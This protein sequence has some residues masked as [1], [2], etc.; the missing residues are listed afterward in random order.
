M[1]AWALASAGT[2]WLAGTQDRALSESWADPE[3]GWGQLVSDIAAV[4]GPALVAVSALLLLPR[5]HMRVSGRAVALAVLQVAVA[6]GG[7]VLLLKVL[8][9][10][11]RPRMV[12]EGEQWGVD[13]DCS[14]G[15][16]QRCRFTAWY[17]PQGPRAGRLSFPSEHAFWGWLPGVA[18]LHWRGVSGAVA[19]RALVWVS[20][21]SF[22]GAVM[23]ARVAVGAHWLS[24]VCATTSI[25]WGW[26]L[27]LWSRGQAAEAAV[28]GQSA[29]ALARGWGEVPARI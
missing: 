15:G 29:P 2:L 18:A 17:A 20:V 25:T 24:D 12:L 7:T 23:L 28:V 8:W 1:W 10:R 16:Q 9:G 19:Q 11:A 5:F 21:L 14:E 22:G 3:S 6:A 4:Q 13:P 26:V 27:L